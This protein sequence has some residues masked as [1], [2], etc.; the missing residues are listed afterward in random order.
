MANNYLIT[1]YWGEPHVT[2]ENDRGFNAAVFGAGRFVLP[3]GEQF[4]AEYIGNNTVRVY[5]GKLLTN[6]ALAGIPAGQYVDLL[7]PEAGQGMNRSDLIVFQYEKDPS[8][9]VE[10]GRF[11]V[12][13]GAESAGTAYD[14]VLTQQDLLT[15]T[16]NLDQMPLWRVTVSGAVINAPAQMFRV[17][18]VKSSGLETLWRNAAPQNPTF[19][20]Q[21][22]LLNVDFS[23]YSEIIVGFL[24]DVKY[25]GDSNVH[26]ATF[27]LS[28]ADFARRCHVCIPLAGRAGYADRFFMLYTDPVGIFFNSSDY[29]AFKEEVDDPASNTVLTPLVIYGKRGEWAK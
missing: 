17:Q 25:A 1:G 19:A 14:P 28:T 22:L 3:V 24:P 6:G 8:T 21:T 29:Y 26:W 23:N 11:V 9:L 7:I 4:R 13:T 27:P 10:T 12:L 5:D 20:N 18:S 2:P 15:D 16:A